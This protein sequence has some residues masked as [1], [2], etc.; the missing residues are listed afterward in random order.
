MRKQMFVKV[1][2]SWNPQYPGKRTD[3]T[4][5]RCHFCGDWVPRT[6]ALYTEH[7]DMLTSEICEKCAEQ[8]PPPKIKSLKDFYLYLI[9]E[10]ERRDA[11]R[12]AR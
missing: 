1:Y 4:D 11:E 10:E 8:P 6:A 3:D 7:G 5:G 9:A 2:L 12:R